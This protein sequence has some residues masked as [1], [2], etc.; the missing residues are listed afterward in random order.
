[1]YH[2][3]SRGNAPQEIFLDDKDSSSF[4]DILAQ[5]IDRL[6][7]RS[8]TFILGACPSVEEECALSE[9]MPYLR[10]DH[11]DYHGFRHP[12][13]LPACQQETQSVSA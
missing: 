12:T 10:R 5:V 6:G 1:V 11:Q 8:H 2:I 9:T 7:A 4:L 3:T 13:L